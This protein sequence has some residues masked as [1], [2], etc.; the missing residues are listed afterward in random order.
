MGMVTFRYVNNNG[1]GFAE[2]AQVAEGTTV[3]QF[4]SSKNPGINFSD[5]NIR[6][7]PPNGVPDLCGSEDVLL[8]GSRLTVTPVKLEG[9]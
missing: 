8:E 2:T 9:E 6:L 4:L 1:G 7:T 5:F 3:S